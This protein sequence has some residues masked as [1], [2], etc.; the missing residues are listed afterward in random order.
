MNIVNFNANHFWFCSFLFV[1]KT[2]LLWFLF[3]SCFYYFILFCISSF[4]INIPFLFHIYFFIIYFFIIYIPICLFHNFVFSFPVS[5]I[6][7]QNLPSV[8]P[9]HSFS[10]ESLF[11][12]FPLTNPLFLNQPFILD[13]I[14]FVIS[15]SNWNLSCTVKCQVFFPFIFPSSFFH[16]SFQLILLNMATLT[17]LHDDKLYIVYSE[18]GL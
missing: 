1:Q 3:K 16:T 13:K 4:I 14:Q 18:L 10:S 5:K 7:N 9:C 8:I 2:I 12:F 6:C 17:P 11:C 15:C